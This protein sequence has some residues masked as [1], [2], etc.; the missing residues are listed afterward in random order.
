M[1]DFAIRSLSRQLAD[2][3][4][5]LDGM[6]TE[7]VEQ[8]DFTVMLLRKRARVLSA[9]LKAALDEKGGPQITPWAPHLPRNAE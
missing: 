7:G 6:L 3:F 9:D 5:G 2:A 1:N 4:L 8:T